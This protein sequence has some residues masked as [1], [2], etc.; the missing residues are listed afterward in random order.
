MFGELLNKYNQCPNFGK[1]VANSSSNAKINNF[2]LLEPI[3]RSLRIRFDSKIAFD[4]ITK[5]PNA[6]LRF[7]RGL[8]MTLEKL[9]NR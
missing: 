3:F 7:L 9:E 5:Q 6:A 1:F 4:I 8:K 2:S